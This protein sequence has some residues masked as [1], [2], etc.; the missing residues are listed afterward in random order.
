ME[1]LRLASTH[2]LSILLLMIMSV[3]CSETDLTSSSVK[4]MTFGASYGSEEAR[5]VLTESVK[6]HWED[7]DAIYVSGSEE[8]FITS[9][10]EPSAAAEFTGEA[11]P[12]ATYYAVYPYSAVSDYADQLVVASLPSIQDAR[13]GS[14]DPAA[15]ISVSSTTDQDKNFVF[16]HA[17]GYLKFTI[18]ESSGKVTSFTVQTIGDEPLSGSFYVDCTETA[19]ELLPDEGQPYVKIV[20][21]TP[22]EAGDYYV[23]MLPGVYSEGLSFTFEGPDGVAVKTIEE[24]LTLERGKINSLGTVSGLEWDNGESFYVKVAQSYDNWSGEYLITYT[25]ASTIKVFNSWTGTDK[26]A[27]TVDLISSLTADGIPSE[28]GDPYK[29]V[30]TKVG[31]YYS[32]YLTGIGYLGCDS[33]D[34]TISKKDSA[35]SSSD[36]KYLW[37][38]TYK[39]GIW[40]TNAS[41]SRRIQW[42]TSASIFRCYTSGQKELTLYRRDKSS[43]G[44]TPSPDP[45]PTPDPD[46]E[47]DPEPE[48]DPDPVPDPVPGTS[49][50]YGWYELPVISYSQSGSYLID[51]DDS[52]LYYAHHICAGSE[53]G[54]GGKKAR[55]YTV[56]FSAEH[57]C[58]VW[59][60]AP[61]HTMYQS[62]A[63]RTN[64][65]AKDPSIPS[66]IQYSSKSTGG[67]CN[68][69]HM[70][71]SAERL[72]STATNKQVFYYSNIAPQYSSTFNTGGG[73]WNILED[74]VDG[75]VCSDTLYVV[76][77]AYFDKYTDRR[78]NT[79][80]PAT[81]SFGGRSD[82]HRPTMFY[83]ILMRTKSGKTGKPLSQCS[84]SEIKCAAFVRSHKTPKSTVVGESDMMSVSDLEKLT[85]FTYFPNVPQAPKNTYKASD[86]GL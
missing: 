41:Y 33:S 45:D 55:N 76:I 24:P 23:A 68:K 62:G 17:V 63:S 15:N 31:D 34:N 54:P 83:Y 78:G 19:P 48:P 67:G 77:G 57:H 39:N 1:R 69:G 27:T 30:F 6:I 35:P 86:W 21:E 9:L 37:N 75:Q 46:P 59:V 3:S 42:N 74:W 2:L 52:N 32:I 40:L 7:G 65:Y 43:T 29:A 44:T 85:G 51:N 36:T 49:G 10:T 73:G 16:H 38:P 64:A 14:F 79:D 11:E 25:T 13:K 5:T 18:G 12:A 61:R 82:V 72:S 84:A 80:Y 26:G 8:P 50:K 53:K 47:P 56:C 60:A 81:I 4:P 58:P 22:L 66:G 28:D 71:G 20:S 70:L